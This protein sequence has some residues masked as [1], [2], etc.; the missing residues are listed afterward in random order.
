MIGVVFAG[1]LGLPDRDPAPPST[2][3]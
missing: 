1:G 2:P 3:C